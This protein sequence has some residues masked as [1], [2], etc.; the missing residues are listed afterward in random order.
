MVPWQGVSVNLLSWTKDL[1]VITGGQKDGQNS[2][3][4]TMALW[5]SMQAQAH[6]H[7]HTL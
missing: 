5:L 7:I 2:K 6:T 4:D 3:M 1:T